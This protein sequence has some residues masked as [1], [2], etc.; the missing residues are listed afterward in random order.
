MRTLTVVLFLFLSQ[1]SAA[2]GAPQEEPKETPEQKAISR[3]LD[4]IQAKD[5]KLLAQQVCDR[6]GRDFKGKD[7][8]D[9][10]TWHLA[11]FHFAEKRF[12]KAQDLLLSLKQSGRENRWTSY[13]AIGLSEVAQKRG[14]D[15]L[16]IRYL[17]EAT[18]LSAVATEPQPRWTRSTRARRHSSDW[19]GTIG[20]RA[21]SRRRWTTTR[22]GS[23]IV[24]AA[25]AWPPCVRSGRRKSSLAGC[26]CGTMLP[27]F[28]TASGSFA[29]RAGWMNSMH[30]C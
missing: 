3:L 17:E 6:V 11:R 28:E 20:T 5:A 24:R 22:A 29:S 12:D 13:A 7:V 16:M 18:K 2:A 1:A 25:L 8:A 15:R 10:A 21:T 23:R 4:A 19:P 9:E 14:D 30:T 26:A 27:Q